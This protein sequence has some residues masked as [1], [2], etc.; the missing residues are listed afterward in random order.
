MKVY[1]M[2]NYQQIYK[3]R[4]GKET[5]VGP[6]KTD[7]PPLLKTILSRGSVR[8]FSQKNICHNKNAKIL[9]KS[10]YCIGNLMWNS[11]LQM[12]CKHI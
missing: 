6:L 9:R 2:L 8:K 7:L 5:K 11:V 10:E 12:K 1:L 3:N 4:Y